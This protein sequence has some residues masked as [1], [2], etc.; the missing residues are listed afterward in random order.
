MTPEW[1]SGLSPGEVQDHGGIRPRPAT[2][3]VW[4]LPL[5]PCPSPLS[6]LFYD[7]W[8]VPAFV[9]KPLLTQGPF[10]DTWSQQC[11][12]YT[13]HLEASGASRRSLAFVPSHI[14]QQGCSVKV[15]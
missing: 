13:S 6:A 1:G 5:E 2:C 7:T 14:Q 11:S 4:T 12:R 15:P 8:K 9:D 10:I 3:R